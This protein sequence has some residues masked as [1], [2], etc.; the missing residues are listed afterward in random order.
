MRFLVISLV[1]CNIITAYP[2]DVY[3]GDEKINNDIYNQFPDQLIKQKCLKNPGRLSCT[4]IADIRKATGHFALLL[5]ASQEKNLNTDYNLSP[6]NEENIENT[7]ED[8]LRPY[9]KMITR[10]KDQGFGLIEINELSSIKQH[11][12]QGVQERAASIETLQFLRAQCKEVLGQDSYAFKYTLF[13]AYET[14]KKLAYKA[15][16]HSYFK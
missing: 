4:S 12:L 9:V 5:K 8:M 3:P 11:I 10:K 2:G 16:W 7:I 15:A 6:F 1:I 14:Y 13:D